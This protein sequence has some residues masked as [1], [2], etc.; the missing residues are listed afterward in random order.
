MRKYGWSKEKA[1]RSLVACSLEALPSALPSRVDMRGVL[2]NCYDQGELGS[3]TANAAAAL[4]QF[5][6]AKQKLAVFMPSRL[7]IYY[8]ERVLEGTIMEDSG[9]SIEDSVKVLY[10][11]G[12]PNEKLWWYNIAKF[13]V[14]PN[15]LVYDDGKKHRIADYKKL[16]NSDIR[17]LKACLAGGFPFVFGFLVYES[18]EDE[19]ATKTGIMTMPKPGEKELGGHAVCALGY[20]DAMKAFIVR[21][22]WGTGWG[23]HGYF[24]MPYEFITNINYCG[25]FWT[26]KSFR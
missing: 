22:S 9:A 19:N 26:S 15:K 23:D 5:I 21:N 17:Q 25:D 16:F 18:F 14:R 10:S 12:C 11:N 13:K 4:A 6:M 7:F 2:P 20:D 24:Y 1:D 3:C 8:N